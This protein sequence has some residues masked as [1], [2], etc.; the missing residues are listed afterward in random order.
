MLRRDIR[1]SLTDEAGEIQSCARRAPEGWC[2][3]GT[4]RCPSAL[5]EKRHNKRTD[6]CMNAG[7]CLCQYQFFPSGRAP[8]SDQM[9]LPISS[10][11]RS[12][13]ARSMRPSWLE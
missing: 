5:S 13:A 6:A 12:M 10:V 8:D 11:A 1:R 9:A 4:R 3:R 2:W 7:V